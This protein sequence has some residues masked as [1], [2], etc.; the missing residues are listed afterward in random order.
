[1]RATADLIKHLRADVAAP[2]EHQS[3]LAV[4]V[5][6]ETA[7]NVDFAT[8][9]SDRLPWFVG[10]VLAIS[11]LL[12]LFGFRSLT[13]SV[14]ALIVNLLSVGAAYGVMV[15]V[16]QWGWLAGPLG[17]SAAPVAPWIPTMLFAI[18]FGLSMDYEVFLIGAI[19]EARSSVA[20]RDVS[21]R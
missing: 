15:A 18:T 5:G 9:T 1:D 14:Q 8:S 17:A 12:L 20:G 11:F 7:G 2:I 4:H 19:R 6:G 13:I 21:A 16:F 10:G 3:G